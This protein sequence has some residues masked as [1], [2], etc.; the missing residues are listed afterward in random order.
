MEGVRNRLA[1]SLVTF[2]SL[3]IP[4]EGDFGI[5]VAS[6]ER[7]D[8]DV[9]W[10]LRDGITVACID[11]GVGGQAHNLN[12]PAVV[13]SMLQA[14]G[15][16][17]CQFIFK[18]LDCST[19][20]AA[21]F[22]PDAQGRPGRPWRDGFH[23]LG[24]VRPDG[25]LP[26]RVQEADQVVALGAQL[27][28][29]V[30]SHGGHFLAETPACRGDGCGGLV[31][32]AEPGDALDG[33][34]AHV[35]M[36]DHPAWRH[37]IEVTNASVTVCDQCMDLDPGTPLSESG[38]KATALLSIEN[39]TQATRSRFGGRRCNH[40]KAAHRVLRGT[41]STGSYKTKGSQA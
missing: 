10:Q 27:G 30:A 13:R 34:E 26:R 11:L 4:D 1:L 7:R 2:E 33:A 40:G 19:R 12:N 32:A 3:G 21:H 24:F 22:L 37:L 18:S 8:G 16:P 23:V 35:Y 20:T 25:T 41:T 17:R 31:T 9:G 15:S 14:A 6:G 29:A 39:T 28:L 36:Y 5:Y 38:E